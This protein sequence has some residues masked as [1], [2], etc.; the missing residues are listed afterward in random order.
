MFDPFGGPLSSFRFSALY[1][2]LMHAFSNLIMSYVNDK[3]E[4]QID[5]HVEAF[6]T[7]LDMFLQ[8]EMVEK[9]TGLVRR[10]MIRCPHFGKN[11]GEWGLSGIGVHLW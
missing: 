7:S 1:N 5:E 2:A 4:D 11:V 3:I 10:W 8:H 6:T 9:R